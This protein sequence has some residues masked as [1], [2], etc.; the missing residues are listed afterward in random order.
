MDKIDASTRAVPSTPDD[1]SAFFEAQAGLSTLRFITCGSVDDGK[2]TLIGR[3]LFESKQI[4]D[5]QLASVANASR[6]HGTQGAQVDLA[7]L[8]D[9]LAA[10][11][12]QGITIDIAYRF[13]ATERRRFIV[14]DTPGH[15]Q[16]TRNMATAASTADLAVLLIDARAGILEQTRRHSHIVSIMGTRHI[17]LAINK[18]DLV[19]HSEERF[20]EIEGQYRE[21]AAE[22]SAFDTLT[23]IPVSALSGANIIERSSAMEWYTGPTLLGHLETVSNDRDSGARPLRMPVQHVVRPNLDF[24]GFSGQIVSGTVRPGDAIRVL[25]SAKPATVKEVWLGEDALDVAETGRSVTL[26]LDREIDV[27]RGDVIVQDD[28]PCEVADQFDTTVLW[29]DETAMLPGRRYDLKCGT[30]TVPASITRIKYRLDVNTFS[31]LAATQL[32]LNEIGHCTVS[33][34]QPIPF[35]SYATSRAMGSFILI[36]RLTNATVGLGMLNFALRRSSNIHRQDMKV[37]REARSDMKGHKAG[38]LWFTGLSGS[39]KSTIADLVEQELL[40]RDIHTM[41]L[42]G[43]NVRHGLNRDLGFTD[44]DRVENIRRIAQVSRL[45]VDAGVLTLVSFIS[46]FREERRM[47]RNTVGEDAFVEVYVNTPLEIAEQ[48]DVKGLYAKARS[49]EITN[50]TGID[51]A[52]EEPQQADI[53]VD[54]SKSTAQEAADQVIS[55]LVERGFIR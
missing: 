21:F 36:D 49:G 18:M 53:T 24:R 3:L 25:P 8:V 20:R 32:E 31:E 6:A 47:A 34:R 7:L 48:R 50:F 26:T 15:E 39:G 2:S 4:F 51:S 1:V 23:A 55:A 42:D 44:A 9:G 40:R 38:V 33:T 14:A 11:R 45:F 17:V 41:V 43:D 29:L 30:R 46:P 12:E 22:L 16:Y 52:Y 13:F 54:T 19:D 37:D 10:E 28:R 5:D 35:E 27:S